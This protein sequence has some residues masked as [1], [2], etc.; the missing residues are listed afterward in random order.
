V[1]HSNRNLTATHELLLAQNDE[2]IGNI[3]FLQPYPVAA[4]AMLET[5][6]ALISAVISLD[7]HLS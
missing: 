3:E 6:T 2:P 1:F 5:D 4:D 7:E